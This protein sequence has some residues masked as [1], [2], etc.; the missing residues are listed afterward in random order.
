MSRFT[1]V[2]S[3]LTA[4]FAFASSAAAQSHVPL[5]IE[6]AGPPMEVELTGADGAYVI[7]ETPCA[8]AAEPGSFELEAHG[9]GVRGTRATLDVTEGGAAWRIRTGGAA[10]FVWGVI[11]TGF[12]AAALGVGS[13]LVAMTLGSAGDD[14]YNQMMAVIGGA[15]GGVIGLAALLGGLALVVSNENGVELGLA[16][17]AGGAMAMARLRL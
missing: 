10:A 3:V 4:V 12:G 8:L 13:V 15:A 1:S 16:P 6:S 2:L 11:L 7:C 14:P 9:R 17:T 5:R